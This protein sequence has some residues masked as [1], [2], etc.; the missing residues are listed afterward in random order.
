MRNDIFLTDSYGNKIIDEKGGF[1]IDIKKVIG[2]AFW[3]GFFTNCNARYRC[4]CGAR[5]TGKSYNMIGYEP[6]FKILFDPNRNILMLRQNDVDNY[7]TTFA[8][9]CKGIDDLGLN[10]R[11]EIR[12]SPYEIVYRLTGQKIIF[13]GLNNPT[14]LNGITFTVGQFTDTYIDE[15]YEVKDV[16]AFE[17][18]DGTMRGILQSNISFYQITLCFNPWSPDTWI[19][20]DFFKG[21]L[22]DDFNLLDNPRVS[23]MD[24]YNKNYIGN[25]GKGLYL[26]KST[27]KANDYRD[28]S[29]WDLTAEEMKKKAPEKYKT[30]YLGMW[31]N[32]TTSVYPEWKDSLIH[33]PIDFVGLDMNG[34]PRM[35][36]SDF[37]IGIDTGLSSNGSKR[38]V[39]KGE[40]PDQ[41]IH[42][43]TTMQLCAITADNR[44]MCV[45]DEYFHSNTKTYSDI[46]TDNKENL[47]QFELVGQCV[48]YIKRWIH[49]YGDNPNT[50]LMKGT[51]EIYVDCADIGFQDALRF[52]CRKENLYNVNVYSSGRKTTTQSRVDFEGAMMGYGDFIVSSNCKNLIREIKNARRGL[53][54]E[55]RIDDD[56]HALTAMEYGFQKMLPS[57]KNYKTFI[58][59]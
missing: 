57:L 12:K 2:K 47:T 43:A 59:E 44:R 5:G 31:G 46:N 55:A 24:Y 16:E 49:I 10:D 7:Q 53:K 38:V 39:R 37:A 1:I 30:M 26:H 20:T 22:D 51:I 48:Q 56:D 29:I 21:N 3:R 54:G 41:R 27:Y 36:F 18:L 19:Y 33:E 15:A 13:R 9:V 11:F 25:F 35:V 28:K 34:Y 52:E 23:Y 6:I 32:T 40:S 42:S 14:A 17:K 8:Q 4:F 58:H 45:I 50:R